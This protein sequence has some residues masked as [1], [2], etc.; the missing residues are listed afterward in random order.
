MKWNT[1][2]LIRKLPVAHI[3]GEDNC[4]IFD[5]VGFYAM[6]TGTDVSGR[7]IVPIFGVKA[8]Q[9]SCLKTSV[10]N[11]ESSSKDRLEN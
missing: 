4:Q 10:T 3:F 1:F 2:N 11:Y 8:V 5:I 7:P 6:Q 9:E